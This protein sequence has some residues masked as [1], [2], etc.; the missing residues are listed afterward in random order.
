M[1]GLRIDTPKFVHT[2]LE[3]P[4]ETILTCIKKEM[5]CGTLKAP[6]FKWLR[7]TNILE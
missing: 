3:P 7:S 1:P 2:V 6:E 5:H 4:R